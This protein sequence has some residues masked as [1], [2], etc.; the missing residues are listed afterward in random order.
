MPR[1]G[2][3]RKMKTKYLFVSI[4]FLAAMLI[5]ITVAGVDIAAY[6]PSDGFVPDER[7]AVRIAEAVLIP[8]YGEQ[9]VAR[10]RPYQASLRN[11]VWII[12]GS[13]PKNVLGGVAKVEISKKNGCVL[14]VIHGK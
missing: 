11:G 9:Q 8:I 5:S 6:V 4:H 12:L 3:R 2:S 10:E 1:I 13:L 7:T 14:S